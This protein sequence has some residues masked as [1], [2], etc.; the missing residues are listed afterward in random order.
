MNKSSSKRWF[1]A[2]PHF[3]VDAVHTF[4]REMRPF[5]D[6]FDYIGKQVELWNQ[7]ASENDTIYVLGDFCNFNS[8]E[9]NW[10]SGMLVSNLIKAHIVLVMGN[11]EERVMKYEFDN[12][13]DK[14]REFCLKSG[15]CRFTDV[16]KDAHIEIKN[17]L[18]YLVHKPSKHSKDCM[19]L[20][21]HTHRAG[22]IYRPYGMNVGVDVNHFRLFS[23]DDIVFLMGKKTKKWDKDVDLN[24]FR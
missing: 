8:H 15:F 3:G 17:Q 20:F 24:C 4:E 9:S 23:E 13:F 5:N 12:D 14:F 7:Q 1:T 19:T 18:Y 6:V 22:G 2:D 11:S 16:V 10:M 21:G